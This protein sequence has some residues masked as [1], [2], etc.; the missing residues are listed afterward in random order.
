MLQSIKPKTRTILLYL[1]IP[2]AAFVFT[3]FYPLCRAVIYSFFEWKGGPNMTFNGL[4]NYRQLFADGVFWEAFYHNIYLVVVCIIGQMGLAFI[5][6]MFANSRL[7]HAKGVHRTF[8]FFPSTISAVCIGMIWNI[9]YLQDGLLNTVLNRL[10]L[11]TG[12]W[13]DWPNWLGSGNVMLAVS[14]PLVWQYIG[15]YMVIMFSA[16]AGIDAEIFE[17]AEIDGANGF[18]KAVKITLPLIKNTILVCLTLCIAGN[19]KAFDNIYVMTS[20]GPGTSS[21]VMAMYGYNT[22]FRDSNLGYGSTISVAIFVLSLAVIGGSQ[23]L[24]KRATK[25]VEL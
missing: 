4:A 1:L 23:W 5:L 13:M 7:T 20:G 25:G 2:V 9:L 22:S 6:V 21:M 15:Y 12:T 10:G 11:I 16:I 3:V 8:G 24:V 17:S 14:I 18:Q 19:M